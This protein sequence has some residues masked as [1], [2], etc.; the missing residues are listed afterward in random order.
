VTAPVLAAGAALLAL[1]AGRELLAGVAGRRRAEPSRPGGLAT[2]L[3]PLLPAEISLRLERAG[4]AS[5]FT[6]AAVLAGKVGC[7]ASGA[8]LSPVF[9]AAGPARITPMVLLA[10]PVVGFLA[11]DIFI[12]RRAR[13]RRAAVLAAL[14]DALDLLGV[15][16]AAGRAPERVLAEIAAATGGPLALELGVALVEVEC[17]APRDAA[18]QGIAR[19]VPGPELAGLAA[20]L[21]RARRLG[22]PLAADLHDRAAALRSQSRGAIEERAA[23]AAPK[24]QL[25]VALLLVPSVMLMLLAALVAHAGALFPGA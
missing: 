17:G 6:P 15:G 14:P 8:M 20:S 3:A 5:R 18:M 10:G 11:P 23:R 19:R 21:D 9:A 1:A 24:I 25:T 7:A 12:A 2:V 22:S 16:V 4:L 13:R